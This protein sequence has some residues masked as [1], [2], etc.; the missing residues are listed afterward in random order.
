MGG[1]RGNAGGGGQS[2]GES[3]LVW[4][5]V[6]VCVGMGLCLG[7]G[8][9]LGPGLWSGV[10][11]GD[12]NGTGAGAC[13]LF[14]VWAGDWDKNCAKMVDE[15]GAGDENLVVSR[16]VDVWVGHYPDVP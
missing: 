2:G 5:G 13:A 12:G 9:E 6:G 10:S 16:V 15:D 1:V 8:L 4:G 14:G 3:V 11:C 7:R